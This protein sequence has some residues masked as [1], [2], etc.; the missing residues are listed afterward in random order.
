MTWTL[1]DCKK[2]HE[3][4]CG[5]GSGNHEL[6]RSI[7]KVMQINSLF[8]ANP[9]IYIRTNLRTA[10]IFLVNQWVTAPAAPCGLDYAIAVPH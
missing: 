5:P 1:L 3:L 10:E 6:E 8:F 7:T 2:K 9:C 4:G